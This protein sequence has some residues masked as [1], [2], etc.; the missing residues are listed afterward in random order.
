MVQWKGDRRA[1][2]RRRRKNNKNTE[3]QQELFQMIDGNGTYYP[4]AYCKCHK[5]YLTANMAKRHKCKSRSC[6]HFESFTPEIIHG[7]VLNEV[8]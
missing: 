2:R 8:L 7:G 5:G 6:P 4:Y 3:R 1:Q